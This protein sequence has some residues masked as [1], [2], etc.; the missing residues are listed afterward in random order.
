MSGYSKKIA[1]E[2]KLDKIRVSAHLAVML[3]GLRVDFAMWKLKT[4]TQ[5]KGHR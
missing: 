3:G 5:V 2:V 4:E 1:L